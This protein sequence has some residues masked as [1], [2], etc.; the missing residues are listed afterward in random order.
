MDA[1]RPPLK[2]DVEAGP[3]LGGQHALSV[4]PNESQD[5][6]QKIGVRLRIGRLGKNSVVGVMG[7]QGRIL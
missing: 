3:Q 4:E 7:F 5:V 2:S 1:S 6:G